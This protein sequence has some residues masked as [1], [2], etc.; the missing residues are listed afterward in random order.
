MSYNK[1]TKVQ[2][3][4]KTVA[5]RSDGRVLKWV[6]SLQKHGYFSIVSVVEDSNQNKKEQSDGAAIEYESLSWRKFFKQRNG[7]P[8]K[9]I[10]YLLKTIKSL[11]R[12]DDVD[13]LIFHDVQQ[14]LNLIFVLFLRI[15]RKKF[16]VWDV[17]ELPHDILMRFYLTRFFLK[18]ILER[19]DLI[20]YT[21]NER[22][23]YMIDKIGFDDTG[24]C[25][26][27]N[28]YPDT[29]FNRSAPQQL[30]EHVRNWLG[31]ERFILWMGA[32]N[33]ARNFDTFIQA[34]DK[35]KSNFKLIIIGKIDE[36]FRNEID[37]LAERDRVFNDFVP[38]VD[39]IKYV[40]NAYFSVVLYNDRSM[41]NFLCEPNRLYQLINRGVPCIVGHNP[42]LSRVITS[43]EA[44]IVLPD[45]GTDARSMIGAFDEM[46]LKREVF[47]DKIRDNDGMY[48]WDE[49]FDVL[50]EM[51]NRRQ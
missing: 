7:Y 24:R 31:E 47:Y 17:H 42:T 12:H 9:I 51:I 29:F 40:D 16:V 6:K 35:F 37:A 10:E 38:Q 18:S 14:Y 45:S 46:I 26:V 25:F 41:N 1:T 2:H 43:N 20:I 8:V 48:S 32:A 5:Y 3:F 33:K 22:R 13:I 4:L 36:I 30:P 15:G 28:N 23:D 21:N 50:G 49:Q 11:R 34:Y 19:I 44:G 27:L 39:I